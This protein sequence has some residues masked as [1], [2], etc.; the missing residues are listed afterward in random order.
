MTALEFLG[1]SIYR[2]ERVSKVPN[3][4]FQR[5][6]AKNAA[7]AEWRRW[8]E[9]M[10]AAAAILV[11]LLVTLLAHAGAWG[12]GSFENDDAL[13]WVAEC[14]N[15]KDTA[16][17]AKALDAVLNSDYIESPDG[18]AAVAAAEVIA[19]ALGR[20]STKLPPEV[21][22]WLR[23]QSLPALAQLAPAAKKV[24]VRIQDPKISELRQLW[25]EGEDA[26]WQAAMADLSA[27][28]GK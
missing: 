20:P 27:R 12:E 13:D 1:N 6:A 16:E 22:S 19:A 17:V 2:L 4:P 18:S 5:I 28:L 10:K 15:S 14:V 3:K 9:N 24:L 21:R 26:N 8:A 7:P 11:A 23:R 25:A